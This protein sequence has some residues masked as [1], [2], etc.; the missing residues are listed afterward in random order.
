[1]FFFFF[2]KRESIRANRPTK[3]LARLER[4]PVCHT[5][6]VSRAYPYLHLPFLASALLMLLA[7]LEK[8]STDT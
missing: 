2:S 5:M 4:T 3:E 8:Q 6:P 1:M 7:V